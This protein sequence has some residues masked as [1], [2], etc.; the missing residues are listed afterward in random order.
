MAFDPIEI[1]LSEVI[2]IMRNNG[3]GNSIELPPTIL[4]F[5]PQHCLLRGFL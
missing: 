2:C 5:S 1:S 3:D 4:L